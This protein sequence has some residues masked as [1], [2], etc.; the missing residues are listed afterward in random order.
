MTRARMAVVLTLTLVGASAYSLRADVRQDQKTHVEFAGALGKVVNI[1]GGK[2][3]R[4]GVTSTVAV[5]GDRKATSNGETGQIIDLNEEKVYDLDFKKQSYKV[6]TFAE[7]RRRME[8]AQKKAEEQA[9]KEKPAPKSEA[10]PSNEPQKEMQIDVDV[11]NTGQTKTINGFNTRQVITTITMHEKGKTLDE[12]GGLVMTAD[13]WLTPK[14]DAVKEISEFDMR[15]WQKLNGPMIMGASPEQMA[16]AMAQ[17][18]MMKDALA[19]MRTEGA[20]VDG[21]AILTTMTTDS[22]KSKEEMAQEQKQSDED[23]KSSASGGV[24]GMFGG[25]AKKMTKKKTEG[26]PSNRT[27]FMT[28]TNEVLKVTTDVAAAD[29]SVPA[30]FKENK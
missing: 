22:V 21:T 25:L 6:T 26:E 20:K 2:A 15:Y 28:T 19:R 11:K 29:V 8:E 5:K 7:L 12:S 30:G 4:E 16:A 13:S 3:A 10:K 17:Y 18:P 24:G 9:A 23:T 14:I 27:T 1:F